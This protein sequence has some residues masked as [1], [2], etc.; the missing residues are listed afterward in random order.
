MN[1]RQLFTSAISTAVL[2]ASFCSLPML[3][4]AEDAKSFRVGMIGLDTS[5]SIAFTK[6]LNDDD[7]PA[8][9]IGKFRLPIKIYCKYL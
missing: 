7:A 8:A 9:S 6:L 5:H 2:V 4:Q 3:A 1:R